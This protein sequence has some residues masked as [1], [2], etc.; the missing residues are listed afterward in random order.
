MT[1][2]AHDRAD[3]VGSFSYAGKQADHAI[4]EIWRPG[5]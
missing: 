2:E 4:F 3:G 1:I 5:L